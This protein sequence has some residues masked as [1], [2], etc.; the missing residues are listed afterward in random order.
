LPFK[1]VSVPPFVE[2]KNAA[3]VFKKLHNLLYRFFL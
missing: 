1:P 2:A 3:D